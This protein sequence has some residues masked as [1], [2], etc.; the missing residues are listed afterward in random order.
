MASTNP[1]GTVEGKN[2]GVHS[3]LVFPSFHP[4]EPKIAGIPLWHAVPI[5]HDEAK[6]HAHALTSLILFNGSTVAK[7]YAPGLI[8]RL[9][10]RLAFQAPFPYMGN[11]AALD[12]AV[13]RRNLAGMLTEYWYGDN[14]V[15]RALGV[16]EIGERPA[17][18]GEYIHGTEPHD[19][20]RA[21]CF[22]FDLATR[23]DGAGLPTWQIDPRQPRSLGNLIERPDGTYAIID[24]ESGL[25]SP[26]ASPRAWRRALRRGSVPIFDEVYFDLTRT[27]ID[28]EAPTMRAARGDGWLTKLY[29]TL[30]AAEAAEQ[31]WHQSEPRIWR[32]LVR[33]FWCVLGIGVPPVAAPALTLMQA[34]ATAEAYQA[35]PNSSDQPQAG[36][37]APR[38]LIG[39][40]TNRG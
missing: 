20:T 40:G 7:I 29:E 12:A 8:P 26:L 18:I 34:A 1:M 17:L 37:L 19:P 4:Y 13:F 11:R 36:M 22:L 28:R 24:L 31:A 10:Y 39:V 38:Q 6:A 32:R 16:E 15:A 3:R 21:R 5:A 25:V 27:Y 35:L 30:D 14:C 9:L 2:A 33:W 23:F